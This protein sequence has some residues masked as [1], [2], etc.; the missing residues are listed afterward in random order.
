MPLAIELIS[1]IQKY[2]LFLYNWTCV[3][4]LRNEPE[5]KTNSHIKMNWINDNIELDMK[6]AAGYRPSLTQRGA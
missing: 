4:N 1:C 5:K 3:H 6:K 2:L